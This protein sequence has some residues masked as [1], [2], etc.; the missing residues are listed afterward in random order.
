MAFHPVFLWKKTTERK[1]SRNE[2]GN[3]RFKKPPEIQEGFFF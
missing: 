1:R 3:V 2:L